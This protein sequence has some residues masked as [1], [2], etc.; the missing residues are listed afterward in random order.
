MNVECVCVC[1]CGGGVRWNSSNRGGCRGL[2]CIPAEFIIREE[3]GAP[4]H[5]YII[6]DDTSLHAPSCSRLYCTFMYVIIWTRGRSILHSDFRIKFTCVILCT[7]HRGC[8]GS[9]YMSIPLRPLAAQTP[10][11]L[12]QSNY[13]T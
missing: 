3:S 4:G 8:G 9:P 1:V 5:T 6:H 10:L 2:H 7:N 13:S 12:P 11:P